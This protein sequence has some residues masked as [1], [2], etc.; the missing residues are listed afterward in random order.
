MR[1]LF[2]G[3]YWFNFMVMMFIPFILVVAAKY[4]NYAILD[5]V[6]LFGA[7]W[8]YFAFFFL[9][10][11]VIIAMR[12]MHAKGD[13]VLPAESKNNLQQVILI[14]VFALAGVALGILKSVITERY[15]WDILI[16]YWVVFMFSL[17]RATE[18]FLDRCRDKKIIF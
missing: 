2:I 10:F 8:L 15:I 11:A 7:L 5:K 13:T 18:Q 14:I 4:K 6:P 3:F 16:V 9:F 1:K 12:I 17:V